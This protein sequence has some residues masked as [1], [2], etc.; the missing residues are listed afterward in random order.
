M[1][2]YLLPLHNRYLLVC[3]GNTSSLSISGFSSYCSSGG[4]SILAFFHARTIENWSLLSV[5][6]C[7]TLAKC[8]IH[9]GHEKD[10]TISVV[11]S[12]RHRV[13]YFV[14]IIR[15]NERGGQYVSS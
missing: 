7:Q 3:R 1:R 4:V 15:N 9:G 12:K 8:Q 14:Q 6:T 11:K 5:R 2:T 13:R 10:T